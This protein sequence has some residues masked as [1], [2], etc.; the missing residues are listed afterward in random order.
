MLGRTVYTWLEIVPL[1]TWISGD[2]RSSRQSGQIEERG[3]TSGE[4]WVPTY[5]KEPV[6]T[7]GGWPGF[8]ANIRCEAFR[9]RKICSTQYFLAAHLRRDSPSI[10]PSHLPPL[11]CE[12]LWMEYAWYRRFRVG[13][14]KSMMDVKWTPDTDRTLDC[15]IR[16]E[17]LCTFRSTCSIDQVPGIVQSSIRHDEY[18]QSCS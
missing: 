2:E 18:G 16:L 9:V 13:S 6:S 11:Q 4:P 8:S 10:P 7:Q 3:C 1:Q 12:W 17:S 5:R 14:T 15:K